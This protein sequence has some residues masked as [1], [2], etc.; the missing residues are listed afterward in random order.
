MTNDLDILFNSL[1]EQLSLF[2][3]DTIDVEILSVDKN[4]ESM[5]S[6]HYSMITLKKNTQFTI[7]IGLDD[8][9]F[10]KSFNSFFEDEVSIEEI[11]ELEDA[12]PCE[13]VNI[14]VGLTICKLPLEYQD[15][16]LGIP[17]KI[18][19]KEI[20]TLLKQND[21]LGFKT[22]TTFGD[23]HCVVVYDK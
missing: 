15:Y 11:K 10:D 22:K 18:N 9:L 14:V 20:I 12:L 23:A 6:S 4:I 21:L 8:E 17:N 19:K 3:R 16:I 1:L 2:L 5:D 7:V 13:I